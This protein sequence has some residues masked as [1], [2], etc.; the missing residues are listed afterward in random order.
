[1]L[2]L[3]GLTTDLANCADSQIRDPRNSCDPWFS[4]ID[5]NA[6]QR[7]TQ[8]NPVERLLPNGHCDC[9]PLFGTRVL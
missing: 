1:M 5:S 7:A 4:G 6:V 8:F 9:G 3:R 2:A